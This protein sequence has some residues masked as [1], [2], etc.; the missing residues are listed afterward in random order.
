M[1]A[2]TSGRQFNVSGRVHGCG[3]SKWRAT[4]PSPRCLSVSRLNTCARKDI[5]DRYQPNKLHQHEQCLNQRSDRP[6]WLI[7]CASQ[8]QDQ[9]PSDVKLEVSSGSDGSSIEYDEESKTVRIPLSA[10]ADDRQARR[11]KL[12]IFTC[13][14]CGHRTARNVNPIAMDKGLVFAQC[15]HCNVWHTI[16][17]NNPKIYE[18]IRFNKE[19]DAAPQSTAS[20]EVSE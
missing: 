2:S 6:R 8:G 19:G 12:I 5:N 13:N 14:K 4:A 15:G 7:S 1:L 18:E 16:A 9:I 11:S 10:L 3:K 17:A 20:G